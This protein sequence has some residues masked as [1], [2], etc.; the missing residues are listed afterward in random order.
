MYDVLIVGAGPAGAATA[1]G[2]AQAGHRVALVDRDRFPRPKSCGELATPRAVDALRELGVDVAPLGH[3]VDHVRLTFGTTEADRRRSTSTTWPD[4]THGVV[5]P[6]E[7]LDTTLVECAVGLGAELLDGHT[8]IE[9]L[10][11]RGFVRGARVAT[12]DRR[13]IDL[14]ATYTVVAD[15][16]SSRFGRALGTY[17]EPDW[18]HAIA[19]RARYRSALHDAAEI[20]LVLGLRDHGGT[21]VTGFGFM[22]PR[23]DGTVNIG[24]MAMST[25]PSFR[26]LSPTRL[27]DAVVADQGPAW[28]VESDPVEAPAG[29]RLPLGASVG[30]TAGP[31]YLVVGDAAGAANPLS[32]AGIEYAVETG[33]LAAAVLAEALHDGTATALQRYPR[34]LDDTYGTYFKVGRLTSRMFGN[35]Q[36]NLRAARMAAS[37]RPAADAFLRLAANQMRPGWGVAETAYRIGRTI[38]LVAPNS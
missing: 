24:V 16:A 32:G 23:G 29:G 1:I 19:Y 21:P 11:N 34:L 9:P 25:S 5:V 30:P 28:H 4:G 35:T 22:F 37:R 33:T 18:P 7:R 26:V 15:G 2:L 8:A 17:R 31:T 10:V 12:P 3:R 6:R 20:E 38:A 36:V 27:L 14:A 13:T